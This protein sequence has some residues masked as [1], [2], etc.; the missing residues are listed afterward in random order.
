MPIRSS[1]RSCAGKH[2]V[3]ERDINVRYLDAPREPA[4]CLLFRNC[5]KKTSR[6]LVL[7]E[8][9]RDLCFGCHEVSGGF[10][11]GHATRRINIIILA[12]SSAR[13]LK[14]ASVGQDSPLR[15]H[16]RTNGSYLC[17]ADVK[18]L[19]CTCTHLPGKAVL[20]GVVATAAAA[21]VAAAARCSTTSTL[22][23]SSQL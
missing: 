18:L 17:P 10:F 22:H 4:L 5:A 1:M 2:P 16:E 15:V 21:A 11:P 20:K 3:S 13:T 7:K 19:V 6:Q 12:R 23:N 14:F 9:N 8:S